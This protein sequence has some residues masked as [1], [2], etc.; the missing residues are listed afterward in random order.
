[1]HLLL[2]W[3]TVSLVIFAASYIFPGIMVTSF[4]VALIVAIVLGFINM[5]I[6]PIVLLFTL[7][8]NIMT[9]G[10]FTFVINAL[11]VMLASVIVPGFFVKN[12]WWALLL[13]LVLSVTNAIMHKEEKRRE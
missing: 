9:L 1:M 3:L 5:V 8:I 13:G 12:F 10:L 2:K 6:R 7:P 11:M 4:V